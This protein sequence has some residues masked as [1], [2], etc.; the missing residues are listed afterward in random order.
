MPLKTDKHIN[1]APIDKID[2]L[3]N[4]EG[5]IFFATPDVLSGLI[6]WAQYD[7]N[8]ADAVSVP[9]G[10]GCSSIISQLVVEN[11][12]NGQKT[13]LGM[14]DPSA[15]PQIEA[16]ILTFGIPMSR[17]KSMYYTIEESCIKGTNDWNKV[18]SRIGKANMSE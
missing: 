17:F 2:S 14:F 10:S 12:K 9:F 13:F 5:I 11:S 6:S 8:S 16:N 7:T 1:F 4:I 18:K 3:E 15:R